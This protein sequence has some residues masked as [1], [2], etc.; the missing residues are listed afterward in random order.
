MLVT[1]PIANALTCSEISSQL[2]PCLSYLRNGGSVSSKCCSG[3]E[4]LNNKS[5]TTPLRQQPCNCF[6]TLASEVSGIKTE[7]ASSL[8]GKCGVNLQY[9]ISWDT[10]CNS[11][12]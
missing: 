10:N 12:K 5:N 7:Y 3:V 2:S 1:A 9:K 11:I 8:P 4:N 6:R